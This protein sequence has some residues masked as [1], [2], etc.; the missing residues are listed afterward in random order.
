MIAA[1]ERAWDW[2]TTATGAANTCPRAA[3]SSVDREGNRSTK[4]GPTL[5]FTSNGPALPKHCSLRFRAQTNVPGPYNVYWQ[6][7]NTGPEAEADDGLRGLIEDRSV[8]HGGLIRKE[9]TLYTGK[10]SIEC[11]IVKDGRLAARSGQFIVNIA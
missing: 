3:G 7:F 11:L 8:E 10:H 5:T 9:S 2:S 4:R 1:P 6:V